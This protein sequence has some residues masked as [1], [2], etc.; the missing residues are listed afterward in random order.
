MENEMENGMDTL[1]NF[2]GVILG[3][4]QEHGK[5]NGNYYILQVLYW[6]YIGRMEKNME[7]TT[8]YGGH[9]GILL[10]GL[11]CDIVTGVIL[12][13]IGLRMENQMEKS[14]EHEMENGGFYG[15]RDYSMTTSKTL[16]GHSRTPRPP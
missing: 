7:T 15:N 2:K 13:V 10:S 14:M 9:I 5:E 12:I 8:F 1:S 4:Y 3:L 6:V 11:Y 16:Q